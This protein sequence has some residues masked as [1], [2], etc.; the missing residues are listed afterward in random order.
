M[1]HV[2]DLHENYPPVAHAPY[3][4]NLASP[5]EE[6]YSRSVDALAS[7]IARCSTLHIPYLVTH[8][9]SHLGTGTEGGVMRIISAVNT[10]IGAF[11]EARR[12]SEAILEQARR[13]A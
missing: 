4:P 5:K 9:G 11:E 10:A 2:S 1:R 7:E 12:I 6:V 8:L 13:V 3:L